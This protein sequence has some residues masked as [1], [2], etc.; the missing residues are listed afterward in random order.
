[1]LSL[2]HFYSETHI[3]YCRMNVVCINFWLLIYINNFVDMY[4]I[5]TVSS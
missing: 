1:M 2:D 3:A 5:L 4:Y